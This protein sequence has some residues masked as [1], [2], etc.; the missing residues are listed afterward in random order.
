MSPIEIVNK[1]LDQDAFSQWLG[2][3]LLEI[4]KGKCILRMKLRNEMTNGFLIAHG[5]IC[6]ALADSC[7]AFAANSYGNQALSLETSISHFK[8]VKVNDE[9]IA[10]THERHRSRKTALYDVEVFNQEKELV[11]LFKGTVYITEKIW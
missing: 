11:A 1:M 8:P 2:I 6:Y 10:K 4:Q 5:G 3:E 7:L 9:L